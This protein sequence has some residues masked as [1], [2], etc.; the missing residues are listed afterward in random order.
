MTFDSGAWEWYCI[1]CCAYRG[2]P[3]EE[4][5]ETYCGVYDF[6]E[7]GRPAPEEVTDDP[8]SGRTP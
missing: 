5:L 1:G 2:A 6:G 7:P 3:D 8:E 4:D